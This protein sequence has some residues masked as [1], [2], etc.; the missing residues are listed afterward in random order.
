M[1]RT[2]TLT[3]GAEEWSCTQCARRLLLRRPPGFEQTVLERGDERAVHVGS[4]G[5]LRLAGTEIG[6]T[7][8]TDLP[9]QDRDWLA[10]HG[11]EWGPGAS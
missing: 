9:A 2:G 7:L 1:T 4:T 10:G 6:P 5:G 8:P 11:I 3:E